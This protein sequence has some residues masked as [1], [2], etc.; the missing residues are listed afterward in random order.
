MN[1]FKNRLSLEEEGIREILL[2]TTRALPLCLDQKIIEKYKT[3]TKLSYRQAVSSQ[4]NNKKKKKEVPLVRLSQTI[5][6]KG[7]PLI[8]N[9]KELQSKTGRKY[10]KNV[11]MTEQMAGLKSE[12]RERLKKANTIYQIIKY[13][14]DKEGFKPHED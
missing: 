11:A 14:V 7:K 4:R 10:Q 8:I 5:Q 9:S 12:R 3:F 6:P 1:S 2:E 13:Y